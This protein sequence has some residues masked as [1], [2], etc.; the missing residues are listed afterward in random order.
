MQEWF[1]QLVKNEVKPLLAKR[2]YAKKNLSFVKAQNNLL[3]SFHLQKSH[4]NS[5]E[6]VMFYVNCG[7]YSPELAQWTTAPAA[8]SA[9]STASASSA[10]S[11][12]SDASDTSASSSASFS[13]SVAAIPDPHA[14]AP[15][16]T[17]RIEELVPAAPSRY[18]LTPDVDPEAF[19]KE[20]N[21]HLTDAIAFLE[22]L[23]NTRAI[24]DYYRDRVALHL[25][26]ENLRYLL[27]HGD[28]ET[29]DQYLQQLQAKYGTETRWA[30]WDG[31]YRAIYAEFD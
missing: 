10:I 24:L 29:A 23:T 21:R 25:S 2:G 28:K 11:G 22:G 5:A 16:F 18:S 4:G 8:S 12:A 17:A 6:Q 14:V 20:L 26:E 19:T 13:P 3:Y 31:K 15:Q 27:H 9:A 7:I 30:I 1:K